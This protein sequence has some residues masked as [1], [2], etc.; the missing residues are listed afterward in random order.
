[1]RDT[2]G[3]GTGEDK[4][5]G[6]KKGISK[7]RFEIISKLVSKGRLSPLDN[8]VST[9]SSRSEFCIRLGGYLEPTRRWGG[10]ENP[11]VD[12]SYNLRRGRVQYLSPTYND[13]IWYVG[14]PLVWY[15]GKRN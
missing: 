3:E 6:S 9:V 1:M 10:M 15:D 12:G 7:S 11:G 4:R 5:V 2:E 13:I 8:S 14:S